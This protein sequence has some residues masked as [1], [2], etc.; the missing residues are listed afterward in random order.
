MSS[1]G[2]K[3][4]LFIILLVLPQILLGQSISGTWT[5][6]SSVG[7]TARYG[8]TSSVIGGKIYV[9][10]GH[11]NNGPSDTIEVYDPSV[12]V[13][14]TPSVTGTFT[15][16]YQHTASVVDGKI[17]IIGGGTPSLISTIEVFDPATN[18]RTTPVTSGNFTKRSLLTSSVFANK[19]YVFGGM[20]NTYS[21]SV[22]TLEIFDP[23]NNS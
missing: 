19:I 2:M 6:A 13:W 1:Y 9:M 23:A 8:L 17:F 14:S 16:R 4:Y 15:R 3:Q 5:T 18:T 11:T 10:S 7:F 20:V 22:N 21:N 12:D